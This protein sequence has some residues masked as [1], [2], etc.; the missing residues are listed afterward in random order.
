MVL[1]ESLAHEFEPS[2]SMIASSRKA[3]S[4]PPILSSVIEPDA[5]PDSSAPFSSLHVL[6]LSCRALRSRATRLE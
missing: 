2:Y 3:Y 4:A 5:Q 1:Q 6:I